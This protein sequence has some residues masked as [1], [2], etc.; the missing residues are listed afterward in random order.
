M[1]ER[2][3]VANAGISASGSKRL[4]FRRPCPVKW[5]MPTRVFH[6]ER[7]FA[8]SALGMGRPSRQAIARTRATEA[9]THTNV[10]VFHGHDYLSPAE[11]GDA[12]CS[13]TSST[14]FKKAVRSGTG[15]TGAA[16]V[17][18]RSTMIV[19]WLTRKLVERQTCFRAQSRLRRRL[20]SSPRKQAGPGPGIG[21]CF[22]SK[23]TL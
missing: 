22:L 9:T 1:H 3:L 8:W 15:A 14:S 6:H 10:A 21:A 16:G 19:P 20:N 2:I 11:Q 18:M 12:A 17:K 4:P 7:C 5:C 23:P 13:T